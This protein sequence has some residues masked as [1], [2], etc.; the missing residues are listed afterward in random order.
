MVEKYF[1]DPAGNTNVKIAD[2]VITRIAQEAATRVEGV[3]NSYTTKRDIGDF[4][5]GRGQSKTKVTADEEKSVVDISIVVEYGRN[6]LEVAEEVQDAVKIS[7]ENMT[8][9]DITAVNVHV[10][11]VR[12]QEKESV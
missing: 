8:D 10:N 11:G 5:P 1:V 6:I 7:L 9:L 12:A 4:L 2:D 3:Y